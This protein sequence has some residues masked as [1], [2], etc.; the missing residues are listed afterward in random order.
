MPYASYITCENHLT[1]F[2][3]R[4]SPTCEVWVQ[5]VRDWNGNVEWTAKYCVPCTSTTYSETG[6]SE[7][8]QQYEYCCCFSDGVLV[9]S[10]CLSFLSWCSTARSEERHA[11]PTPLLIGRSQMSG[12]R[13]ILHINSVVLLPYCCIPRG[14]WGRD[15]HSMCWARQAFSP[16]NTIP[17]NGIGFA[18]GR[19]KRIR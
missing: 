18:L 13:D 11:K 12:L 3:S 10:E 14:I 1:L 5:F 6:V 19:S 4:L 9:M 7:A 17:E 8:L 15:G 2:P 16:W